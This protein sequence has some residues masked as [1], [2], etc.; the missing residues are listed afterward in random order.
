MRTIRRHPRVQ[1]DLI[2]IYRYL[3]ERSPQ[4]AEKVYAAIERSIRALLETPGIGTL[5]STTDPRLVGLRVTPCKPYRNYLLFFK[6]VRD[7]IELYRVVHGARELG[8]VVADIEIHFDDDDLDD[9]AD[10]DDHA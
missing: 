3:H 8:R 10:D 7:G 6:P 1:D 5:W 9:E 2:D 4:A